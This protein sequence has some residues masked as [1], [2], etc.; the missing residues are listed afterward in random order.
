[1]HIQRKTS[2][3]TANCGCRQEGYRHAHKVTQGPS[4]AAQAGPFNQAPHRAAPAA[5]A[6]V[7][8]AANH[9][10]LS[11]MLLTLLE[12]CNCCYCCCC[13]CCCCC[14]HRAQCAPSVLVTQHSLWHSTALLVIPKRLLLLL[15]SQGPMCPQCACDFLWHSTALLVIPKRLL[16]PCW[17]TATAGAASAQL[18]AS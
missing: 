9:W 16:L 3:E 12:L 7:A 15:Q 13:C 1:M 11:D 5:A 17:L 4:H 10:W 6:A 14:N 2:W 18:A 8:A